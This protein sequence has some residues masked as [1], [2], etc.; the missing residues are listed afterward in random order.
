M[1]IYSDSLLHLAAQLYYVDGMSQARLGQY[2]KVSQAKVSRILAMA[3]E[4]GIVRIIVADFSPR[5][6]ELETKLRVQLGLN[7]A[8][9][10]KTPQELP[11]E[12]VRKILGRFAAVEVEA[13]IKPHDIVAIGSGRN[14]QELVRNF[15]LAGNKHITVVQSVGNVDASVHDFDAQEIG[16]VLSQRLG[17]DFLAL[18]M[19]A[20]VH[21]KKM[22]DA[23]FTID[24]FRVINAHLSKARVALVG[25]G[26]LDQSVFIER[27][28][29]SEKD[30]AELKAAGAVGEIGGRFYDARGREC[31]TRWRNQV[32]SIELK[33][34]AAIPQVIG[35][36]SGTDRA[37]TILAAIAGS[38][39]KGLVINDTGARALLAAFACPAKARSESKKQK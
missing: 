11:T 20:F 24:Q 3:Q 38:F 34:L 30:I 10:I 23:L 18:N 35:V 36:V 26:T 33:Q 7:T 2:L 25:V 5:D 14:V 13:I 15:S 28:M 9:V 31:D 29:L 37:G 27:S 39:L 22:R 1:N 16:R 19:P 8:V 12:E 6:H 4:R 21:T 17:G 32:V